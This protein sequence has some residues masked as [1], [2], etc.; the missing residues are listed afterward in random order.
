MHKC[1]LLIV[2]TATSTTTTCH[3]H[4][5]LAAWLPAACVGACDTS[6]AHKKEPPDTDK[7]TSTVISNIIIIS[8]T[9]TDTQ[10][11]Y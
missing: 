5:S 3:G 2:R 7:R 1:T 9:E 4:S 10:P 8:P 11:Y 6:C